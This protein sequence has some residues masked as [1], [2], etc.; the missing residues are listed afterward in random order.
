MCARC[1]WPWSRTCA[2]VL[3]QVGG[4]AAQYANAGAFEAGAQESI[5]RETLDH[6]RASG[7]QAGMGKVRGELEDSPS[8]IPTL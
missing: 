4:P 1:C 2:W 7:S 5:A 6:L 8:A 3:I